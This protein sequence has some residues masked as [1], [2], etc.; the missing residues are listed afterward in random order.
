[1]SLFFL[2]FCRYEG[3]IQIQ[4]KQSKAMQCNSECYNPHQR[5]LSLRR[6]DTTT[7]RL[8][9]RVFNVENDAIPTNGIQS[10]E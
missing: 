10:K 1:M 6:I 4:A 5:L 2:L 9:D 8:F 7:L 3:K